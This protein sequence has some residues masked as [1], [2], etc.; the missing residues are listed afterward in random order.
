V[1]AA[2]VVRLGQ[3]EALSMV[4]LRNSKWAKWDLSLSL[5][6]CLSVCRSL[7]CNCR[8]Q[9]RKQKTTMLISM[10]IEEEGAKEM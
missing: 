1:R 2:N 10:G 8:M 4:L 3:V 6:V 7:L 9:W 5:S